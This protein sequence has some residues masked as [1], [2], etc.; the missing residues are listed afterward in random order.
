MTAEIIRHFYFVINKDLN[1]MNR[2]ADIA[3]FGIAIWLAVELGTN[4]VDTT[5]KIFV[6]VY[7]VL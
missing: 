1:V 2:F 3:L 4:E 6:I 7:L 5:L